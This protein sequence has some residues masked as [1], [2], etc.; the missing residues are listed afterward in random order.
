MVQLISHDSVTYLSKYTILEIL[1]FKKFGEKLVSYLPLSH[2]AAQCTDVFAPLSTGI[3]IYFAQPDALKSSLVQTLTEVNPTMFFGVPRVF[4][5]MQERITGIIKS[6]GGVKL[7]L[8]QWAR[9]QAAEKVNL[10]FK[11][12]EETSLAFKIANALVLKKNKTF[13]RSHSMQTS[14][15]WC[16]ADPKR[17]FRIFL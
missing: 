3:T 5:K 6:S 9:K 4:E 14:L 2:I 10:M 1:K 15:Q 7:A 11:G 17:H 16:C 13:T 8:L 12:Q